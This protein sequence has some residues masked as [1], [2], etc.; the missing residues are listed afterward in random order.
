VLFWC[1]QSLYK[2]LPQ[3]DVVFARI[4]SIAKRCKFVFI[5]SPLSDRI[6]N[7]FRQRLRDAFAQRQLNDEDHCVFLPF[8]DAES[9]M[10]M[11]AIADVFLDSIGWNGN[12]SSLE[13]IAYDVPIVTLP[14]D[15]MRGRHTI[16]HLKMM[17][18]EELIASS[19]DEYVQLAVRLAQDPT[20]RARIASR[21]ATSK[22][23]LYR[24]RATIEAL[25]D[26][27]LAKVRAGQRA[28][29]DVLA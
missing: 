20:Y 2:Y 7:V 8:M 17:G 19:V 29:S 3:Y 21:I 6:T 28:G 22:H 9:F 26:F 12:N 10:G 16:A 24:D 25:Q 1:C 5:A 18:M 14:L 23:K 4:A 27:I 13:A 15:T 11:T